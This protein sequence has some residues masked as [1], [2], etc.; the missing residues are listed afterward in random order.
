[1]PKPEP[2]PPKPGDDPENPEAAAKRAQEIADAEAAALQAAADA[3]GTGAKAHR[4]HAEAQRVA[5][6]TAFMKSR[7]TP[8]VHE[9]IVEKAATKLGIKDPKKAGEGMKAIMN[10]TH[11]I[12]DV[13]A[14]EAKAADSDID[15]QQAAIEQI[16]SDCLDFID[17]KDMTEEQFL[18]KIKARG[19]TITLDDSKAF[20]ETVRGLAQDIEDKL[21]SQLS[22]DG[23]KGWYRLRK[24][25]K[26]KFSR[27]PTREDLKKLLSAPL[28]K[29]WNPDRKDWDFKPNEEVQNLLDQ[30]DPYVQKLIKEVEDGLDRERVG[31]GEPDPKDKKKSAIEWIF[32]I[33]QLLLIAGGLAFLIWMIAQ[34]QQDNSGCIE[35]Q[36]LGGK[37]ATETQTKVYCWSDGTNNATSFS[38]QNCLCLSSRNRP[39]S[40]PDHPQP[41]IYSDNNPYP[42]DA[43]TPGTGTPPESDKCIPP[44][45]SPQTNSTCNKILP[46]AQP[47]TAPGNKACLSPDPQHDSAYGCV[48]KSSC[49]G[50]DGCLAIKPEQMGLPPCLNPSTSAPPPYRYYSYRIL[51][52]GGA[53]WKW[54]SEAPDPAKD[55][56][57]II[58][59]VLIVLA[60]ISAVGLVIWGIVEI[61]MKAESRKGKGTQVSIVSDEHHNSKG[62]KA[63]EAHSSKKE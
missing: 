7:L 6:N 15:V 60:I 55:F 9:K 3:T 12:E 47:C 41:C 27:S 21:V 13:L 14:K 43:P 28:D 52:W 5:T 4:E 35:V 26:G 34:F 32:R 1:M 54:T 37:D 42:C 30:K 29:V 44:T 2:E 23:K 46:L 25:W 19:G 11:D 10:Y 22:P 56:L 8:E 63:H 45:N 17:N 40:P 20:V 58:A 24:G 33:L 38:A 50:K 49:S 51:S 48:S 57:K 18:E 31:K 61:I 53:L 36:N 39:G 59:K 16:L 62:S